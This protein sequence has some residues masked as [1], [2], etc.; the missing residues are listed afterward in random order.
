MKKTIFL[1]AAALLLTGCSTMQPYVEEIPDDVETIEQVII[2]DAAFA[3]EF[4]ETEESAE[5]ADITEEVIPI[6]EEAPPAEEPSDEKSDEEVTLVPGMW[7]YKV[8]GM[9]AGYYFIYED[10]LSGCT[11]SYE[12]GTGVGFTLKVGIN[13][14]TFCYGGEGEGTL[15]QIRGGDQSYIE[16][17]EDEDSP[18][19]VLAHFSDGTPEDV[20]GVFFSDMELTDMAIAYCEKQ[21]G[22]RCEN[23]GIQ[24]HEDG[25]V[26]IVLDGGVAQYTVDRHNAE[27]TD[28]LTG[29]PIMIIPV[30]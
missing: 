26:T 24:Y 28:D 9:P 19:I 6:T 15:Y 16:M 22:V 23:T 10:G 8:D 7:T 29:E 14:I 3:P 11:L 17:Q 30:E 2:D 20:E 1:M 21:T 5:T 27:G 25:T 18:Y 13:E 4:Y 12:T